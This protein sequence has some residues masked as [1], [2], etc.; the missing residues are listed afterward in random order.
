MLHL[1]SW[2]VKSI[3]A[4]DFG[5]GSAVDLSSVYRNIWVI[6]SLVQRTMAVQKYLTVLW[7]F[8]TDMRNDRRLFDCY[9]L[10]VIYSGPFDPEPTHR[11]DRSEGVD[12]RA[13]IE[14]KEERDGTDG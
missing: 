13:T 9:S 6:P 11:I 3:S 1:R 14:E 5:Q 4:L 10:D 8:P 2:F 7:A 12:I